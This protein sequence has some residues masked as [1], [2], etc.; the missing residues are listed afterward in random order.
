MST[1]IEP[2]R[3]SSFERVEDDLEIKT[4]LSQNFELYR[5]LGPPPKS[6][7]LQIPIPPGGSGYQDK[8]DSFITHT[9]IIS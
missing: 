5:V 9:L 2:Q 8:G 1:Q 7:R 6:H 3:S 4:A